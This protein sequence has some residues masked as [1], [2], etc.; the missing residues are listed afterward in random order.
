MPLYNIGAPKWLMIISGI[1]MAL[2]D[3]VSWFET[4]YYTIKNRRYTPTFFY[5]NMIHN[6]GNILFYVFYPHTKPDIPLHEG[7][8][9]IDWFPH[10][11]IKNFRIE[12]FKWNRFHWEIIGW[13]ILI[14][15]HYAY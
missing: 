7:T 15:V 14:G 2:P 9:G 13:L 12:H 10:I 1:Y 11:K 8:G 6:K 4:A 5:Y 3:A